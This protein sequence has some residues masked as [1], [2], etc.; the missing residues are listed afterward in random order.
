MISE[1]TGSIATVV[2]SKLTIQNSKFESSISIIDPLFRILDTDTIIKDSLFRE[3]KN[4]GA[5]QI[6]SS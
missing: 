5:F 6:K 1:I 2:K 3:V 4:K